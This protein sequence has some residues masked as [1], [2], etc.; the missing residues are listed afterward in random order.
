MV[1]PKI[2]KLNNLPCA[3]CDALGHTL[4]NNKM[5]LVFVTLA[6][7]PMWNE[8]S[9]KYPDTQHKMLHRVIHDSTTVARLQKYFHDYRIISEHYEF[10][11]NGNLHSHCLV[12][13]PDTFGGYE[14]NLMLISKMYHKIIGLQYNNSQI[15]CNTK[16]VKD[17]DIYIYLNKEN[18]Y[19]AYHD[20]DKPITLL[21]Y[22][23]Q[24]Q[25]SE[26]AECNE[27]GE[28]VSD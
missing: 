8:F 4:L 9:E 12:A 7:N 19:D 2:D 10:A 26:P 14:R 17:K 21:H 18:A 15:A 16:W 24:P 3:K 28:D 13:I 25:E 1:K 6:P 27:Q 22:M 5:L 20:G 11:R 23:T